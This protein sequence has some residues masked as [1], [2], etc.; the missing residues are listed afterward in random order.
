MCGFVFNISYVTALEEKIRQLESRMDSGEFGT[1]SS[2]ENM[3]DPSNETGFPLSPTSVKDVLELDDSQSFEVLEFGKYPD[4][5]PQV[6]IVGG[7]SLFS[8]VS[9]LGSIPA[10]D[11]T[12]RNISSPSRSIRSP[13]N[14]IQPSLSGNGVVRSSREL[15]DDVFALP[16]R[17]VAELLSELFFRH[18]YV[19]YPFV[20]EKCFRE[21]LSKTYE[22]KNSD[23]FRD[24]RHV[25]WL[26]LMNLVFA[27]G[28]DYVDLPLL[29]IHS[30]ARIF[31]GRAND[32]II[33]VCFEIGTIQVLQS[34]LL[35]S[36]HLLSTMQLN[37]CWASVGCLLR[38]GQGLG[39][40]LNP[41][42]WNIPPLE[43]EMRKRLWWGIYCLDRYRAS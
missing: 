33:S 29:K 38:T 21:Q 39:L 6:L 41:D 23:A 15:P 26:S 20:D 22:E 16:E 40:H 18:V 5:R 17:P 9:D 13:S 34:L 42:D 12:N 11:H 35:L 1:Q 2:G 32:L 30:L 36:I 27:F 10:T 43:K 25:P 31:A 4:F 3:Q 24:R 7:V 19:F 28:C 37:K 14:I 8:A